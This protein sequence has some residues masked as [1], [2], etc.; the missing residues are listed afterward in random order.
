MNTS[1]IHVSHFTKGLYVGGLK[2]T[3]EERLLAIQHLFSWVILKH[4]QFR[5]EELTC[6]IFFRM[7]N[8][9]LERTPVAGSVMF[10]DWIPKVID[11]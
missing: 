9:T 2:A 10:S 6:G 5:K 4:Q 3:L 7:D 8:N 1:R 11:L